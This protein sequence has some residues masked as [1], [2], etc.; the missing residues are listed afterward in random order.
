[1]ACCS[2]EP[3]TSVTEKRPLQSASSSLELVYKQYRRWSGLAHT[4][5][6]ATQALMA[7]DSGANFTFLLRSTKD[8]PTL[9]SPTPDHK[10]SKS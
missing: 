7:L 10:R 1:M 6:R 8:D 9:L 3:G 2:G 5:G 4:Q